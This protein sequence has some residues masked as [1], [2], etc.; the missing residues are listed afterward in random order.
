[1]KLH[2]ASGNLGPNDDEDDSPTERFERPSLAEVTA[3]T[4]EIKVKCAMRFE[5]MVA[6][7]KRRVK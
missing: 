1:M 7:K 3:V 6:A 2:I 5:H 4:S